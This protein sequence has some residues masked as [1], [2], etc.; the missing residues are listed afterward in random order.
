MKLTGISEVHRELVPVDKK[1]MSHLIEKRARNKRDKC[2]DD[3]RY[4]ERHNL[5]ENPQMILRHLTDAYQIGK[6]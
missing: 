2:T 4:M 5:R 6:K 3:N 1:K